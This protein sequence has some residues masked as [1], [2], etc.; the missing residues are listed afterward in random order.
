MPVVKKMYDEMVPKQISETEFWTR[1]LQS[2]FFYRDR[3]T[4]K[5]KDPLFDKAAME[6]EEQL[7]KQSVQRGG[8]RNFLSDLTR[9]EG[10][11]EFGGAGTSLAG[12]KSSSSVIRRLNRHGE[13]VLQSEE[14]GRTSLDKPKHVIS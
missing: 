14:T 13:L 1:C 4:N 8:T 7:Q 6:E 3:Q 10:V 2:A 12:G 11:N 5:I 9:N